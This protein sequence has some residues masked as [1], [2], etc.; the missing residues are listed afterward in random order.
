MAL[1]ADVFPSEYEEDR[2]LEAIAIDDNLLDPEIRDAL[3]GWGDFEELQDDFIQAAMTAKEEEESKDKDDAD[4]DEFDFDA[5]VARLIKKAEEKEVVMCGKGKMIDEAPNVLE[6]NEMSLKQVRFEDIAARADMEDDGRSQMSSSRYYEAPVR[7][8]R[9]IDEQF[10]AVLSKYGDE[11]IGEGDEEEYDSDHAE[12]RKE[13]V[14]EGIDEELLMYL[15]DDYL[16][17]K[18]NEKVIKHDEEGGEVSKDEHETLKKKTLGIIEKE[19]LEEGEEVEEGE[20]E[21]RRKEEEES[22]RITER[23]R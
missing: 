11:E 19:V 4:V 1:P 22:N 21:E 18:K 20:E 12:D 13:R 14:G 3:D 23:R 15:M 7:K 10:A 16:E 8:Q 17:T 9:L 2:M 5:H 6:S